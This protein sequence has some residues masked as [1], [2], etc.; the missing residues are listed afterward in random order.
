MSSDSQLLAAGFLLS[1][2][3]ILLLAGWAA[4]GAVHLLL[5]ASL[6]LAGKGLRAR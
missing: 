3:F 6:V 2:W 4:G 1:G 5:A